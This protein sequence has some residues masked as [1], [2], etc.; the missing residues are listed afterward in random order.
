MSQDE[1]NGEIVASSGAG[2]VREKKPNIF[3]RIAL[4]LR[5]VIAELRKV[6]TPTRKELFKFTGVVLGF[7]VIMMAMIYGLDIV[8]SWMAEL[9]FGIPN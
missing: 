7:V 5:Q 2:T 4:F 6:V 3:A 1:A 8:F 9:V